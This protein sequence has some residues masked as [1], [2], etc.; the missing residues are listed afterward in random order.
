MGKRV[1]GRGGQST[2]EYIL[3]LAA[4]LVAVILMA[5]SQIKPATENALKNSA[6]V[7]NSASNKLANGLGLGL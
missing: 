4:I 7:I 2:L 3:V 6:S 1:Q 5:N